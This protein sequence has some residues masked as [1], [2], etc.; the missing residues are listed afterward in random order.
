[1][2]WLD[3]PM[4]HPRVLQ[5]VLSLAPGGTE[6]LVLELV[7]RLHA[8]IP[9]AVCCLD[10]A[11][12]WGRDLQTEGIEVSVLGRQEGFHP[13]LGRAVAAAARRHRATVIHAHHYSPFVYSALARLWGGPGHVIFTEHGRLSDAGP[14]RKRRLANAVLG[15][16][17]SRVFTVSRELGQHLAEEGF[18]ARRLGVIYNGIAIGPAP[19]PAERAEIRARLGVT[20]DVLVVGTVARL[21]PVKDL[22]TLIEATRL[23]AARAPIRLVIVGDGSERGSLEDAAVEA[24]IGDH[25]MFLGHRDDARAWLAGFDVY[26]NSS[27]SEGVSL[28][29][30]EAMAAGLPV[31]ATRVGGTP[32]VVDESCGRLV[33]ARDA[34]ALATALLELRSNPETI[35]ALHAA[36]RARVER[37]F[38]I[39]RMVADYAGV[40]EGRATRDEA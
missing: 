39:E 16:G 21:D 29:I 24:G 31:V 5:V 30:L 12:A 23:V 35:H 15:Y 20:N 7:R 36:A 19:T 2:E 25:V 6:R 3:R 4:S 1:M 34:S 32:E 13:Q 22:G 27:I 33:P 10:E 9:M 37:Q 14:S 8:S 11:G 26:A 17:A 38:T 40:Y 28:T 18:P